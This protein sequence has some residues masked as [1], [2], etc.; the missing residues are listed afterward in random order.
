VLRQRREQAG[1]TQPAV[2]RAAQISVR[3][4]RRLEYGGCRTRRSTLARLA[5]ALTPTTSHPDAPDAPC[6]YS[7]LVE[8]AGVALA[9]ESAF[10]DR[11]ARRRQRRAAGGGAAVDRLAVAEVVGGIVERRARAWVDGDGQVQRR[12]TYTLRTWDG[13]RQVV[14]EDQVPVDLFAAFPLPRS[15]SGTTGGRRAG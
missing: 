8:V 10:A 5:A 14:Q 12:V 3:H 4:L 7:E 9:P 2:A 13:R 15:W 6:L 1:L 11:V